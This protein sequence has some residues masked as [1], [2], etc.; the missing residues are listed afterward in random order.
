MKRLVSELV[1]GTTLEVDDLVRKIAIPRQ[2]SHSIAVAAGIMQMIILLDFNEIPWNKKRRDVVKFLFSET[3]LPEYSHFSVINH[4]NRSTP[5]FEQLGNSSRTPTPT[6]SAISQPLA[7]P[8]PSEPSR[9]SV[10]ASLYRNHHIQCSMHV[11]PRKTTRKRALEK[12]QKWRTPKGSQKI[13]ASN[14]V[15]CSLS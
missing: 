8:S 15:L 3:M 13:L 5:P 4:Q 1:D 6:E 14:S 2:R 11:I 9:S 12:L 7:L 10:T